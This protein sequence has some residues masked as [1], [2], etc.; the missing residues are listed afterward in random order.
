MNEIDEELREHFQALREVELARIPSFAELTRRPVFVRA[1]R[2]KRVRWMFGGAV[3][4][5][6]AASMLTVLVQRRREAEWLDA[7]AAIA[8]WQPPTDALLRIPDRSLLHGQPAVLGTSVL[9]SLIPAI[10]K[11]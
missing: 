8:R 9:D 5:L 1:A 7:A 2:R 10:R 11:D 3:G 4:T 6:A